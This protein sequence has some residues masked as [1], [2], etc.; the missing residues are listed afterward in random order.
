MVTKKKLGAFNT[1]I[2]IKIATSYMTLERI[3]CSFRGLPPK[4]KC[5]SKMKLSKTE[6]LQSDCIIV[7]NIM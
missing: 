3:L 5:L 4:K 7:K 6:T 2:H 1:N